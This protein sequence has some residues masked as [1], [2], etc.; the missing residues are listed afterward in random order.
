MRGGP[1]GVGAFV[2]I[3]L[4]SLRNLTDY[5][6]LSGPNPPIAP[7]PIGIANMA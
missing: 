3:C 6:A 4:M 5:L 7:T 2:T 1:L